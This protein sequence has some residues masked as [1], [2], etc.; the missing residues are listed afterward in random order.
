MSKRSSGSITEGSLPSV[1]LPDRGVSGGPKCGRADGNHE[2]RQGAHL[3]CAHRVLGADAYLGGSCAGIA[4][5]RAHRPPVAYG[6]HP[7]GCPK[8]RA[9]GLKVGLK[10]PLTCVTV[11]DG[12]IFLPP[13][14]SLSV[15]R[16]AVRPPSAAREY[17]ARTMQPN[18]Q[19]REAAPLMRHSMFDAGSLPSVQAGRNTDR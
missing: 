16:A 18:D 12:R 15:A 10:K 2:W 7:F 3:A 8:K 17:A 1:R 9:L 4:L 6:F 5:L 11:G 13:P 19:G 14:T